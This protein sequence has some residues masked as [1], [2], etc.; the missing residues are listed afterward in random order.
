[1]T[2]VSIDNSKLLEI[3]KN[4]DEI[5]SYIGESDTNLRGY[6]V[7]RHFVPSTASRSLTMFKLLKNSR[8]YYTVVS[9]YIL[10]N[11]WMYNAKST[12]ASQN[13]DQ[14]ISTDEQNWEK[15]VVSNFHEL[16]EQNKFD[17]VIT[18]VM[19]PFDHK[20]GLDIKSKN[21]DIFWIALWSDPVAFSPYADKAGDFEDPQEIKKKRYEL[22]IFNKADLLIFTNH[23][24]LVFM[25]D[26]ELEKFSSKSI[27]VHHGFD[28][29]YYPKNHINKDTEKIVLAYIGHMDDY[30]NLYELAKGVQLSKFKDRF[31]IRLI[32]HVPD[33]QLQFLKENDLDHIFH[34]YGELSWH[35]CLIEMKKCDVLVSMDPK[36]KNMDYSQQMSSK[37]ADYLGSR[38]PVLFMSFERGISADVARLTGNKLIRNEKNAIS[39]TLDDIAVFGVWSPNLEGYEIYN[40]RNVSREM[41]KEISKRLAK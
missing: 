6:V 21:P 3:K 17:F 30:R 27:V 36:Y 20:I 34:Y 35:D 12:L 19:P 31:E 4:I 38:K 40:A 18:C 23:H 33:E 26:K 16:N 37:I 8:F 7:S 41:D 13:I 5:K 28:D 9:Q 24:Q 10:N 14:F 15:F 25:L 39:E 29:D 22:E 2:D 1:M 11:K 32:G